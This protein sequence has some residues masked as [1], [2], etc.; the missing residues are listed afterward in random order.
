MDETNQTTQVFAPVE[1]PSE[2]PESLSQPVEAVA[3]AEHQ[4][5]KLS[6][7]QEKK[8]KK[9]KKEKGQEKKVFFFSILT[10]VVLT[11]SGLGYYFSQL[12]A[13]R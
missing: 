12:Q 3:A 2:A 10:L 4:S 1:S 13:H 5:K 9:V 6:E 8:E 7:R 11:L